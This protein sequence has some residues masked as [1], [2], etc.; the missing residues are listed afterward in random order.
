MRMVLVRKTQDIRRHNS[1]M[2]KLLKVL[3]GEKSSSLMG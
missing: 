1:A 2:S 3:P